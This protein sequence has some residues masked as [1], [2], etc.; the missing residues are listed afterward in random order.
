MLPTFR[1]SKGDKHI[2]M[3]NIYIGQC[4]LGLKKNPKS[5]QNQVQQK[6]TYHIRPLIFFFLI[7]TYGYPLYLLK[8]HIQTFWGLIKSQG[9]HQNTVHA[10]P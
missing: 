1:N 3:Y 8:E 7:V 9:N 10:T 4:A 5:T 6:H 2:K